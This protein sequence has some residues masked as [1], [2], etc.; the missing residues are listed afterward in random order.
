ME[1]VYFEF[2]NEKEKWNEFIIN[3]ALDGGLL[4][5]WQGGELAEKE[6]SKIWRIGLKD[7]DGLLAAS[8]AI[9]ENL[10]L[11]TSSLYLPRG[12]VIEKSIANQTES[13]KKIL[14]IFLSEL[15]KIGAKESVMVIKLDLPL[16][17]SDV[18]SRSLAD[19]GLRRS[20]KDIQPR[21]TLI[22]DIRKSENELLAQMKPKTRYNIKLAEKKQIKV[23][24]I[25]SISVSKDKKDFEEFFNLL[26]KTAKRDGFS[27]HPKK[28]YQHLL[29]TSLVKLFLAHYQ[30]K[31]IAGAMVGFFGKTAIYLHGA[32]SSEQRNLM[33]PYLLQWQAIARARESG[34]DYYDFG[35]IK[36]EK[37][38]NYTQ[39]AWAGVT[40]FKT[41]FASNIGPTEF[42]GVWEYNL[43]PLTYFIYRSLSKVAR[44]IRKSRHL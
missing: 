43:K 36:S 22:L 4:Q 44:V 15:K 2:E 16:K 18:Q 11:K 37:E 10:P 31:I 35:G 9:K 26:S 21:T 23:N 30:E 3:N 25:S 34:C 38:L 13:V 6:G 24:I 20:Y 41:G 28:H 1:V 14:N 40:R 33:A 12:P 5:S 29:E 39:R 42:L 27:I 7:K 8:L 17:E 32:S 19:L